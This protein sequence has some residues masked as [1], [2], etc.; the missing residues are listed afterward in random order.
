MREL[1]GHLGD[2]TLQRRAP[3]H[4]R[5]MTAAEL[6]VPIRLKDTEGEAKV[7]Q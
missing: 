3:A 4:R 6:D 1:G 5:Q 2:L 7:A